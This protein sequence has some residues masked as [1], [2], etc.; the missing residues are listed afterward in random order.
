[1]HQSMHDFRRL[2]EETGLSHSQISALFQLFHCGGCGV[3]DIGER[4][5]ITNAAASQITERLVQQ[6]LILRAEAPH[7]RRYKRLVLTVAGRAVVE[8]GLGYRQ[9]WVED[10][11]TALTPEEQSVIV[12]ALSL[13]TAAAGKLEAEQREAVK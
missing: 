6:G 3:S 1:M 13:L 8:K 7:D 9:R 2:M 11:T 5:G 10:L 4:L 12:H